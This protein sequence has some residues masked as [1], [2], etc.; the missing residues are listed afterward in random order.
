[1]AEYAYRCDICGKPCELNLYI[2]NRCI[3]TECEQKIMRAKLGSR[4][5]DRMKRNLSGM[6]DQI[7]REQQHR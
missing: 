3:C 1:M 2:L 6:L 7:V 5:Y 4:G